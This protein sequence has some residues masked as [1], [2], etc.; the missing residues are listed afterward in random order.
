M[1]LYRLREILG[2]FLVVAVLVGTILVLGSAIIFVQEAILRAL[3]LAKTGV[4]LLE[5][6][7]MKGTTSPKGRW[8][9]RF[10]SKPGFGFPRWL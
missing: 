7:P 2:V 6:G 8:S 3:R 10:K 9:M 4:A 1:D 5:G